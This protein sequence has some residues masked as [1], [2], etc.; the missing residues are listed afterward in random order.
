MSDTIGTV[1]KW[2]IRMDWAIQNPDTF[3]LVARAAW[4]QCSGDID[5]T[6]KRVA[7]RIDLLMKHPEEERHLA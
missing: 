7:K 3:R 4:A 6:R 2:K 5:G 1:A